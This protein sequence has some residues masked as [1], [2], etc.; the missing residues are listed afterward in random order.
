MCIAIAHA[1]D[2]NAMAPS[3][4][5]FACLAIRRHA[6]VPTR[7][8][9]SL[10]ATSCQASHSNG[11]KMEH[12]SLRLILST[13]Y[14]MLWTHTLCA[15]FSLLC[16]LSFNFIFVLLVAYGFGNTLRTKIENQSISLNQSVMLSFGPR[17]KSTLSIA[18]LT[19]EMMILRF[20]YDKFY[21]N[22][23][24]KSTHFDFRYQRSPNTSD[25]IGRNVQITH[26]RYMHSIGLYRYFR[27]G[28][29]WFVEILRT[30]RQS[31]LRHWCETVIAF[32]WIT[33]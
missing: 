19:I 1:V 33:P 18:A 7:T 23:I 20:I 4:S 11:T 26:H 24:L 25:W 16:S 14:F 5:R 8:W 6:C 30:I 17:L 9:K 3:W 32:N 28:Q 29:R 31:L 10:L 27:F 2:S 21:A 22:A 12:I 13:T 15:K